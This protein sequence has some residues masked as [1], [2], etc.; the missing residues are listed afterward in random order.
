M[1]R[2]QRD[3]DRISPLDMSNLRVEE[4]GLP[5]HMAALCLLDGRPLRDEA[6]ELDVAR[7]R[8]YV[9]GR[10]REVRRLHQV[11]AWPDGRHGSPRWRDAPGFDIAEHV[12]SRRV[13]A[14][15][16]E[17]ALLR[18][19]AD[20]NRPPLDRSRPL[21]EVWLLD[22]LADGRVALLLRLHH[23][24]ADGIAAV[25]LFSSLFDGASPAAD[26]APVVT[27]PD[28]QPPG[29]SRIAGHVVVRARQAWA[30]ARS[31]RAPAL[32]WNRPVGARQVHRLVRSDLALAKAAAHAHGGKVNDLVLAAVGGGAHRLL[33]SRHELRPGVD[34][35]VSVAAS[36]RRTGESGGNRV[37][38][39]LVPVPVS[40]ADPGHRLDTVARRTAAQRGEPPLQPSGRYLQRW[41]VRI[42]AR[43]RLINLVL[44]N[45]PGPPEPLWFAGAPVQEM[46]QLS[47]LQG[48]CAIGVG[49]LSYAGRLT[50]DIVADADVVP[51]V[52]VFADGVAE[53]LG[54]LGA[55]GG[56]QAA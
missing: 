15:R 18:L 41:M 49:V 11:L 2:D 39:R 9:D 6:G 51:D 55:S 7:I 3:A 46:F 53:T 14:P 23:V 26:A 54:H 42:M 12:R 37:A 44:S 27:A 48:N 28:G 16:D 25:G 17:A 40:E 34:M 21:W 8:R 36:I 19:C 38:V 35:R 1:T 43:Q 4:R 32:S 20:L 50:F 47:M 56:P 5:M 45:L 13:P 31:G 10:T 52:E 22:G 24:V 29:L 33:E 30:L